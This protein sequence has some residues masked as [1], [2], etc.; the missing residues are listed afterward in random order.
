MERRRP[1]SVFCETFVAEHSVSKI[2]KIQAPLDLVFLA[3][4]ASWRER[5]W[6]RPQAALGGSRIS[7]LK[8]CG[9]WPVNRA[10]RGNEP[11]VGQAATLRF[12]IDY[13]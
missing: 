9:W 4:L 12:G 1:F 3:F 13:R 11:L 2:A 10:P 7:R 6:L 5:I 8:G